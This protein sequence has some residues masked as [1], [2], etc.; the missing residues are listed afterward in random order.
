MAEGAPQRD[1]DLRD[2]RVRAEIDRQVGARVM[3]YRRLLGLSRQ[4]M[5]ARIGISMGQLHKYETAVNRISAGML[6]RIAGALGVEVQTLGQR[7]HVGVPHHHGDRIA[8]P[9]HHRR[10]PV[11]KG[12]R[13]R[14]RTRGCFA[15]GPRRV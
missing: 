9:W 5:A 12:L 3:E 1:N 15:Y 10:K 6:H 2:A 13:R 11:A 7:D 4:A 8:V 14:L